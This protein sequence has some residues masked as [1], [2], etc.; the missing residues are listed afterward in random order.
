MSIAKFK[1]RL[2]SGLA[3]GLLSMA[4][5]QCGFAGPL[6][7]V[8]TPLFLGSQVEPNLILAMDDSGSMDF[9]VLLPAGDGAAWWQ[10]GTSGA[11]V[12]ANSFTGCTRN[13]AAT[14]NV[15]SAG[16]LNFNISGQ[17]S[18]TWIK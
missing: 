9:E 7:I 5:L 15:V 6:A 10:T 13:A 11:C 16:T 17:Q 12:T 2:L 1:R 8:N 18:T 4:T 3:A 14:A